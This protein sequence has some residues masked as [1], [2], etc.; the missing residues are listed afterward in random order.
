MDWPHIVYNKKTGKTPGLKGSM[1]RTGKKR[2]TGTD[3]LMRCLIGKRH[4]SQ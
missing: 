3:L 2:R 1:D 4:N